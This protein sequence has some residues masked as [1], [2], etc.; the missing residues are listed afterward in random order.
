M[1]ID[2]ID[3]DNVDYK[4]IKKFTACHRIRLHAPKNKDI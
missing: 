2:R 4:V 3:G 1:E